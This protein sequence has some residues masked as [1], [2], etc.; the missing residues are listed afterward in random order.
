MDVERLNTLMFSAESQQ[1]DPDYGG[2]DWDQF[3]ADVLADGFAI[4]RSAV[5]R[6]LEG[7]AAFLETTRSANPQ[8]R[9][10]VAGSVRVWQSESVAAVVCVIE[11]EGRTEQF[12][13]SRVFTVGG[14]YG[15]RCSWWQVTAAQAAAS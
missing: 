7:R 4:R 10:I 6:P 11:V 9:T 14:R 1:D 5:D 3:L 15:W 12:T 2:A 13:N 8:K